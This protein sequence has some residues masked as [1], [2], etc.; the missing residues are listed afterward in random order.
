MSEETVG[1]VR[2]IYE[3]FGRGDVEAVLGTF[4]ADIE[5]YE[6]EGMP[7]GG[8]FRGPEAVAT[9]VFAPI[10]EDV[11]GF[12]VEPGE[13][14]DGGD[15]VVALGHY[16]GRGRRTGTEMRVPFAHA[17]TIRDGKA[18]RFRQYVDTVT[19]NQVVGQPAAV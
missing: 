17:W 2:G 13:L 4:H 1:V 9:N 12:A 10:V 18:A 3:A 6:A 11:E 19:F 8:L 7:N 14:I 16:T 5:W 15:E